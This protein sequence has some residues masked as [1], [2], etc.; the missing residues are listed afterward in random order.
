MLGK[1]MTTK[2]TTGEKKSGYVKGEKGAG[3]R[4]QRGE[5]PTRQT[6]HPTRL[7]ALNEG[8]GRQSRSKGRTRREI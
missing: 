2:L 4:I 8:T 1:Y 7:L 6:T 5:K 3:N